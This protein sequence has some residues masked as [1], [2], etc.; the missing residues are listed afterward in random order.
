MSILYY[1]VIGNEGRVLGF[2]F[3]YVPRF[4]NFRLRFGRPDG[5]VR[6]NN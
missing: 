3:D 4:F 2:L 1:F 6:V 5:E